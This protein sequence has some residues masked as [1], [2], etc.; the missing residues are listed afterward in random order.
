[1]NVN[2]DLGERAGPDEAILPLIDSANVCC[3]AHAGS[4]TDTLATL[5]RCAELG[6]EVGA[7]PGYDDREHFG[8]AEVELSLPELEALIRYQVGAVAA[9]ARLGYIKAHGALY[10]H[11]QAHPDAAE[12]LARVAADF[13]VGLMGQPGF[14]IIDACRRAGVPAYREGFADRAYLPSGLLA[15]R[16]QAGAVLGPEAAAAQALRLAGSGEYDT[17]CLH[18]DSPGAEATARQIRQALALNGVQT[19]PLASVRH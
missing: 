12:V 4:V 8:R 15:P 7:H 10:H 18:G 16:A 17:I 2:S 5:R 13:H 1:M 11:C 14:A 19:G 3:G 6:L 9:V